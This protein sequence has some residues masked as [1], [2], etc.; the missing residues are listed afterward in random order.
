MNRNLKLAFGHSLCLRMADIVRVIQSED[1][2]TQ[3]MAARWRAIQSATS[4]ASPTRTVKCPSHSRPVCSESVLPTQFYFQI[5]HNHGETNW[6]GKTRK[7]SRSGNVCHSLL[8]VRV[9]IVERNQAF[10]RYLTSSV[11]FTTSNWLLE[12]HFYFPPCSSA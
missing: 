2:V 10:R 4:K 1:Y 5:H 9:T 6:I 12:V 8:F 3:Q 11:V 7:N